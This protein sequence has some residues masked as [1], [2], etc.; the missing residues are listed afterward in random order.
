MVSGI[1]QI[2]PSFDSK[3]QKEVVLRSQNRKGLAPRARPLLVE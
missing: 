1:K 3:G 2:K